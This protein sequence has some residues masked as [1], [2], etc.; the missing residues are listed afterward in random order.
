MHYPSHR[1][2]E[3][4]VT[5]VGRWDILPGIDNALPERGNAV[6]VAERA[7]LWH[8]ATEEKIKQR[9]HIHH[10]GGTEAGGNPL[11]RN[12]GDTLGEE[13]NQTPML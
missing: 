5:I 10:R 6:T 11:R 4:P 8:V 2:K 9:I 7:I 1:R 13:R 12:G 3:N